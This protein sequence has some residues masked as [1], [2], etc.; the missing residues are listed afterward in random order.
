MIVLKGC[1]SGLDNYGRG[2]MSDV[3][4]PKECSILHL[5]RRL[6]IL[7]RFACLPCNSLPVI[8]RVRVVT[9]VSPMNRMKRNYHVSVSLY[10]HDVRV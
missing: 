5:E 8:D 9:I 7:I 10:H 4:T 1:S 3:S 2:E 6:L